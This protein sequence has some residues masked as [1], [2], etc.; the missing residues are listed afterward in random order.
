MLPI[1]MA[2]LVV[3]VVALGGGKHPKPRLPS[4]SDHNGGSVFRTLERS[5][6]SA[7]LD[8]LERLVARDSSVLRDAHQLAHALGRQAFTETGNDP[9][10]IGQ[11][12]PDFASGCYHGVVEAYLH[13]RGSIDMAYL[14]RMCRDAAKASPGTAYEC[15]HGLGHGVLGAVNLDVPAALSYCDSLSTPMFRSSC[16]EGV[17][18]ET[19]NS[20]VGGHAGH[21]HGSASASPTVERSD[22]Y[23]P[24]DR[25]ADRYADSCWLFQGFLILR[26]VGF[27]PAPAF[28]ACD[29]APSGMTKRCYQSIGH[30]LTGLFQRDDDW[31]ARQCARGRPELAPECAA[32]AA[33]ALAG[34]DWSGM[35]AAKFCAS[36]PETWKPDCYSSAARLAAQLATRPELTQ[37]C[38][39]MEPTY[40]PAC[41]RA[42]G[43]LN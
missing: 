13:V 20:S 12:R 3:G 6:L 22:P 31:V 42:V 10:V 7:A 28:R 1:L 25:V 41:R 32:G 21:R 30:Q 35:R 16:H 23:A 8:T 39:T 19:I 40:A 9:G 5:G 29:A 24:C 43:L 17:F 34:M 37:L 4:R 27:D 2:T 11:C 15:M 33:W 26:S 18:M 14:E 36:A 38:S